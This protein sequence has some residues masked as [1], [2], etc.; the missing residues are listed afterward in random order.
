MKPKIS[1]IIPVY[2]SEEFINQC[3]Q[4]ILNQTLK[5]L[6]VIIINDGSTD[7][8]LSIIKKIAL[9]DGRI[10]FKTITNSGVAVARNKGLEIASGEFV[11][12]VDSDDYIDSQMYEKLY[13]TAVKHN[14][15]IV[16]CNFI[17]TDGMQISYNKQFLEGLFESQDIRRHIFPK[18]LISESLSETIPKT[19]V[20]KIFNNELI[21]KNN[22]KFISES[23]MGEDTL[24]TTEALMCCNNV[25]YLADSYF[26]KYRYNPDSATHSYLKGVWQSLEK[27]QDHIKLLINTHNLSQLSNQF[28]YVVVRDAITAVTNEGRSF[29]FRFFLER[30]NNIR[31]ICNLEKVENAIMRIN[32][33]EFPKMKKIVFHLIRM[34]LPTAILFLAVIY[35]IHYKKN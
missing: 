24:F 35:N 7:D 13:K 20:T 22:I 12:F 25:Y 11:G 31:R 26:Y 10:K 8:S 2:N 1:I 21:K 4:S 32:P 3:I 14:C 18:L 15:E 33:S 6:E 23:A 27:N 9:R 28:F 19:L 34:K 29:S 17:R 16:S 30:L 5:D